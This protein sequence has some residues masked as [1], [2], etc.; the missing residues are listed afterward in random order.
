[1]F[2]LAVVFAQTIEARCKVESEDVVGAV[3]SGDVQPQF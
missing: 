1:M 3:P 2:P